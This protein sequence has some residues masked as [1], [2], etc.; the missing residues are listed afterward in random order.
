MEEKI[1]LKTIRE[2]SIN[3]FLMFTIT[4]FYGC[5]EKGGAHVQ[6][7]SSWGS[8]GNG[9]GQFLYIED[10]A[11]DRNGNLLVTDALKADVQV[12]SR[13]GKF[14]TKF[15]DKV[16]EDQKFEKPE[17]IAVD[18]NGNIFVSDYL[19]GYIKKFDKKYNHLK[20]IGGFG[21]QE[22]MTIEAELMGE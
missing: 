10:F 7:V 12:F 22:G 18:K 21:E 17:G 19:S 6:L 3:L 16:K 14:L 9:N 15:G 1:A 4:T 2:C 11:F 5:S 8:K 20:T 13:E